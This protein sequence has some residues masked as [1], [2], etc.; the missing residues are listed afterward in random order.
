MVT[1]FHEPIY[2][3]FCKFFAF[4]TPAWIGA[5]YF[6]GN[7]WHQVLPWQ[8]FF[9]KLKIDLLEGKKLTLETIRKERVNRFIT[10]SRIQ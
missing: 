7:T 2:N 10:K 3:Y 4:Q 1:L 6:F 8:R 9:E 5:D